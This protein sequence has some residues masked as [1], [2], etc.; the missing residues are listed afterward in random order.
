M[1]DLTVMLTASGSQFAPGII[2][3]FKKN[4]ER[5]ISVIG[6]DMGSNPSN[7]YL[8]DKFYQIPPAKAPDYVQ[9][10]VE[11]CEKEKVDI[12]F[13]QMSAELSAYLD[14]INLFKKIGTLVAMTLNENVKVAN[15]KLKLYCFLKECGIPI[16]EFECVYSIEE[17]DD[18]VVKLGYPDH[19][20]CVKVTESSGSRGIRIIDNKRSRFDL[21]AYEKPASLYTSLQNMRS[22]L[23][24]PVQFP[25]LLLMKYLPGEEYTVDLLADHGKVLYIAGRRNSVMLMSISQETILEKDER[26]YQIAEQ[27]VSK[28]KLDGNIGLDFMFD[29]DGYAQLMEVNPRLDATVSLCAAAGLNLPYLRIKQLLGEVLPEITVQYGVNLKRRYLE[30]FID[31]NGQ[32]MDW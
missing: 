6:G 32:L 26:A 19:P 3:C 13:P 24:E 11:I 5:E 30:L 29:A 15:N 18:A 22:I 8:V 23:Q 27:V 10:V 20:V 12:L 17:F 7:K 14:N 28:L 4:G 16:P 31:A 21:F 25:E 1:R 2:K 9:K